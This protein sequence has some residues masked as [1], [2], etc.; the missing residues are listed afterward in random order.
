MSADAMA[1]LLLED[2]SVTGITIS[3]GEPMMQ[4]QPLARMV[5]E[6]RKQRDLNV[7][8][9]TGFN[10]KTLRSGFPSN[11]TELLAVVDLLIDGPYVDSKNTGYGI[12]GSTN[13]TLH[14]L[15]KALTDHAEELVSGRRLPEIHLSR[16][17]SI[18]V[19]IPPKAARDHTVA[20]LR[21]L[22]PKIKIRYEMAAE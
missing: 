3:G 1:G 13:Q 18:M 4:A 10:L 5:K 20:A 8:C 7:I 21:E 12:R 9:Y 19:G 14:F 22:M 15:T 16:G 17:K 2:P 11:A 6:A